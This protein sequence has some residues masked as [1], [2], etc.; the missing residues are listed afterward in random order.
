M[1]CLTAGCEGF[2]GLLVVDS[3][4]TLEQRKRKKHTCRILLAYNY[5]TDKEWVVSSRNINQPTKFCSLLCLHMFCLSLIRFI[6]FPRC[7]RSHHPAETD[8]HPHPSHNVLVF[9]GYH[10]GSLTV[11]PIHKK[12]EITIYYQPKQCIEFFWEI[13]QNCHRFPLFASPQKMGSIL[14][15]FQGLGNG[16]TPSAA[17]KASAS[18]SKGPAWKLRKLLSST[19]DFLRNPK[20][21]HRLDGFW[22]QSEMMG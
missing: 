20:A 16:E 10:T 8:I 1:P 9:L 19:I 11:V 7:L 13:P 22:N 14:S 21:N 17:S 12:T 5:P 3:P 15:E 2:F 4:C 18:K 6:R